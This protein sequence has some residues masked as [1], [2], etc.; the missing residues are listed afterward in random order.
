MT[1]ALVFR[2]LTRAQGRA[3]KRLRDGSWRIDFP[4]KEILHVIGDWIFN[5]GA[6]RAYRAKGLDFHADLVKVIAA[7]QV[8]NRA[9][10][11][12]LSDLLAALKA[13]ISPP[14]P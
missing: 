1:E 7:W 9:V 3:Q 8:A 5:R 12:D 11:S 10:P 13:R 2:L 6:D 14:A 4:G